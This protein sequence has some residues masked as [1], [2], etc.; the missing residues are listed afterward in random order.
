MFPESPSPGTESR[1]EIRL[2]YALRDGL[3]GDY[4]AFHHVAWLFPGNEG[5]RVGEADFVI[6]HPTLGTVVVEAK[7]GGIRYDGERGQFFSVGRAGEFEIK[8]PFDQARRSA[9]VLA[10]ALRTR[11]EPRPEIGY[12]VAFPDAVVGQAPMRPD[13]PREVIIGAEDL[14]SVAQS[15]QGLLKFWHRRAGGFTD[16]VALRRLLAKSFEIHV[17]LS[18]ELEENERELIRL[19]ESQYRVLDVLARQT[20]VA[21]GGCAGS[22]KTFIAAEKARRL[23]AQGFR[24]LLTCFNRLLAE[25]LRRHLADAPDIDVLA[26]DELCERVVR[27]RDL[28]LSSVQRPN[29]ETD[30]NALRSR[31]AELVSDSPVRYGAAIV[32]EA[33]DFQD[34]WWLPLQIVLDDPD[35]SPFYVFYDSNQRLFPQAR[36]LPISGE[37]MLL[38][39]NCRNT[40]AINELVRHYYDGPPAEA[41]GPLGLPIE[42]HVYH[43]RDELRSQLDETVRRLR[44]EANLSAGDIALLTAHGQNESVLWRDDTVGGLTLTD[45]PWDER[46]V[47]RASVYRFKGLERRVVLALELDS[48]TKDA[49]YVLFSRPKVYLGV[50]VSP[51]MFRQLPWKVQRKLGKVA[52]PA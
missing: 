49:L 1:A 9:Y 15:V 28:D 21:I 33:Q 44:E 39:V 4:L 22:G 13:A 14:T 3:D 35:K 42:W 10:D 29:G 7:G 31:F 6:A 36:R 26:Y 16:I 43:S 5:A 23:S 12:G 48:A 52:S 8:D 47:L 25:F 38:T 40:K 34:D 27:E 45:D 37:P 11:S 24:V 41:L 30:W 51:A 20:R 2:F 18:L 17:P 50:F 32:D 46:R 19:T